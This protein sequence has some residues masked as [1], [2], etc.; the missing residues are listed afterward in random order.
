MSVTPKS[1]RPKREKSSTTVPR[2]GELEQVRE[3]L[4]SMQKDLEARELHELDR[5]SGEDSKI[6]GEID[7]LRMSQTGLVRGMNDLAELVQARSSL[8]RTITLN[9]RRV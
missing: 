5:L 7:E 4:F 3:E 6:W 2:R 8:L 1:T 9:H